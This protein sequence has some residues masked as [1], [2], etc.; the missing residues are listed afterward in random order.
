MSTAFDKVWHEGLIFKLKQ[1]GITGNLIRLLENYLSNREQRVAL[2]GVFSDWGKINSGIP[3]GSVL[4]PLLFIA[5]V[6]DLEERIKSEIIFFADDTSIFSIVK[7][8]Q[9][10][11]DDLNYDLQLI[12]EW[13]FQ[14]KM[15]FNPDA[16]K[17]AEEII[18]SNK[19]EK[20]VH[21]PL[22]FNNVEVKQAS[23]VYSRF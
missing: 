5:Y 12:N 19:R 10:S 2:N 17:P 3:Q 8:S 11:A 7:K 1:N 22:Y 18:F 16:S 21:P 14:W 13:A 20:V 23:R 15:S 4:G 6:N 9:I